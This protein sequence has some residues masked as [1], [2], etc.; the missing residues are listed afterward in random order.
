MA[1][2]KKFKLSP[3][4]SRQLVRLFLKTIPIPFVPGPELFDIVS[5]IRKSQSN[6]DIQVNE[7]IESLKK[8]TELISQLEEGVE[9]RSKKLTKLR[10]EYNRYSK[11]TEIE[12]DKAEALIKQLEIT[13]GKGKKIERLFSLGLN[14]IAGFIVFVAGVILSDPLKTLFSTI[15]TKIAGP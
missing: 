12:A 2:K 15:W 3:S 5:D 9:E 14:L 11:L 6:M 10:D 13:L 7:A 4:L 1:D 8:T